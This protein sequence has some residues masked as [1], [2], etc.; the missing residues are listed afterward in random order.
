M[1]TTTTTT[2]GGGGKGGKGKASFYGLM[3]LALIG[4]RGGMN[5]V[6]GYGGSAFSAPRPRASSPLPAGLG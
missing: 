5:T 3:R 2:G 1:A 6:Q 4:P